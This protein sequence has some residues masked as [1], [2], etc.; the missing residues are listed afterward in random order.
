MRRIIFVSFVLLTYLGI[1]AVIPQ[2]ISTSF[3]P[4]SSKIEITWWHFWPEGAGNATINE[5]IA[6]FEK[7]N[8]NIKIKTRGLTWDTG[9]EEIV[10]V[11]ELGQ[12]PDILELGADM[13][14]EFL[15]ERRLLDITDG[16][17]DVKDKYHGWEPVVFENKIYGLP[18]VL[19]TRALYVN[20][21]ILKLAGLDPEIERNTWEE[22]LTVVKKIY[23]AK[24]KNKELSGKYA[25][26]LNGP[27]RHVLFKKILPFVWSNAADV[28]SSDGLEVTVDNEKVIEG[29]KYYLSFKPYAYVG[30]QQV[31]D[32]MFA[33]GKLG[34]WI[35]GSWVI[36]KIE[37]INPKL[38]YRVECIPKPSPYAEKTISYFGGEYLVISNTTKFPQECIEFV[39]FV[40]NKENTL[41]FCKNVGMFFPAV[42]DALNDTFYQ[43][44]SRKKFV[45]QLSSS[46]TPPPNKLWMYMKDIF[47]IEM[48]KVING[49]VELSEAIKDMK[50]SINKFFNL[51]K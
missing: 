21:D 18:W 7:N 32:K 38:N 33:E 37:K 6:E 24:F 43:T 27:E 20:K 50:T 9:H 12:P 4:S 3:A 34:F 15:F 19:D 5:L 29:I 47:E 45:E 23:K 17:S 51:F 8:P 39:K 35:S 11:M 16:V 49:E 44:E 13:V 14:A 2:A 31:L 1:E 40:A 42:K 26:G 36:N 30:K 25:I 41:R 22:L 46:K 28:I 48:G 10:A